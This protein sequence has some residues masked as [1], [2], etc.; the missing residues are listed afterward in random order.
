MHEILTRLW[1]SAAG[2]CS[3]RFAK[4]I[5]HLFLLKILGENFRHSIFSCLTLLFNQLFLLST[6]TSLLHAKKLSLLSLLNHPKNLHGVSFR[7]FI[8]R[9]WKNFI[10]SFF[11]SLWSHWKKNRLNEKWPGKFT[12]NLV[13]A[14]NGGIGK[15][16][17]FLHEKLKDWKI[18]LWEKFD[19]FFM[20]KIRKTQK[21]I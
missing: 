1:S 14:E 12:A 19:N 3:S 5:V 15:F 11:S 21:K 17:I 8:L 10:N 2:L 16:W 4:Q 18:Y 13:Q 9:R 6:V 7:N 20:K